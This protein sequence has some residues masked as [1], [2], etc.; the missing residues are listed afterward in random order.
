[1]DAYYKTKNFEICIFHDKFRGYF[2][3]NRLGEDC[4]GGLW[5]ECGKLTD[6]DGVFTLPAEV[7]MKLKEL[8]YEV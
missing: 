2:E 1:M 5:F 3:H 8:G 6:Y 4:A 7:E